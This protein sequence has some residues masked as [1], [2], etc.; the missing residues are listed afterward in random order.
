MHFSAGRSQIRKNTHWTEITNYAIVELLGV[1]ATCNEKDL[2]S[3]D[4]WTVQ[5]GTA[6]I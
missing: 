6:G 2:A 1:K 3:F 5:F 4:D